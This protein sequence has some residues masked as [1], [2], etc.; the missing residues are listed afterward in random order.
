VQHDEIARHMHVERL[1][2][3]R[4]LHLE[5]VSKTLS[6]GPGALR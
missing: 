1:K 5:E 4:W 3:N 2:R 6:N